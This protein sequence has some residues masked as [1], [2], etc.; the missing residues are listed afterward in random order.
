MLNKARRVTTAGA[1]AHIY[2]PADLI[3]KDVIGVI[4]R[5]RIPHKDDTNLEYYVEV[6]NDVSL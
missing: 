3:G 1:T 6:S 5:E 4:I 2:L